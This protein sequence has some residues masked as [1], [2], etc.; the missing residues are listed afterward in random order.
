MTY[1]PPPK[2]LP[3]Y[4]VTM[5]VGISTNFEET[6]TSSPLLPF[7]RQAACASRDQGSPV[8]QLPDYLFSSL[9]ERYL[10]TCH[11]EDFYTGYRQVNH[12][13]KS[14]ESGPLRTGEDWH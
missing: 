3:P 5:G 6:Q 12:R 11:T 4:T 8:G 1:L 2:S 9:V 13:V 10:N 7:P 14:Y